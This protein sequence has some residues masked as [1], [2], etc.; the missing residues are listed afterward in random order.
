SDAPPQ[1]GTE[2]RGIPRETLRRALGLLA[3]AGWKTSGQ[4]LRNA[5]G[6]RLEFEI[7]LV[8]PSLERILQPYVANLASLGISANLRTVDRAQYKQRLDQF[9][10]DMILL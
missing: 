2:G 6:Q 4:E 7:M 5:R 8:N 10:Y 1:P 9:D 3:D